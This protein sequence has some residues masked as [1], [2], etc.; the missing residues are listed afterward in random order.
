MEAHGAS[1]RRAC[2]VVGLSRSVQRYEPK[3]PDD[4]AL[5]D[6]LAELAERHPRFGFRKLFVLLR[7]AGHPWNH[8]R[9]WRVYC[10][11]KLNHRRRFKKRY[12]PEAPERLLQ[13]L[14]PNQ[15]WS[16]DFMSDALYDGRAFRTFNVIDD[17]NREALRVEVDVSLTAER[18]LRVLDQLLVV[19]GRPERIR[20]DHGP[21]FTSAVFVGWC[22]THGIE[23]EYTQPG[24]PNQNGFVERFNGSYRNGVLNAWLFM[25]LEHVREETERW[26]AEYNTIRPHESLG[27]ISP[28]EFLN[29]RGHAGVSIYDWA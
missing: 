18:V 2:R 11:M 1:A 22:Q 10:A 6:V 8:K 15:A 4:G 26:L 9:V 21:E 3:R 27:D 13:P 24:K 16:A 25:D 29:D 19:R 12:R 7:K 28:L 20:V 5:I 23:L 14:R 17:Y